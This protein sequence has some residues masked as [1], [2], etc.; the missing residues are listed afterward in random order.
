MSEGE[1]GCLV[2]FTGLADLH[3]QQVVSTAFVAATFRQP[4]FHRGVPSVHKTERLR[5]GWRI[6]IAAGMLA[7]KYRCECRQTSRRS[8]H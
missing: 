4:S 7:S 3:D 6:A 5:A 2:V 1:L 8:D